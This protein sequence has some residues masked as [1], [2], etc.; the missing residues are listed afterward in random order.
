MITSLEKLRRSQQNFWMR[1]KQDF[2]AAN[3][4][5]EQRH[6][7]AG[8]HG[9]KRRPQR[10]D[11]R[12]A[13]AQRPIFYRSGTTISSSTP[14]PSI[15]SAKMRNLS[16]QSAA[17]GGAALN[18]FNDRSGACGGKMG[19]H[20]RG[21]GRQS[22]VHAHLN[23]FRIGRIFR[24]TPPP[25]PRIKHAQSAKTSQEAD[26][27]KLVERVFSQSRRRRTTPAHLFAHLPISS[28]IRIGALV[29]PSPKTKQV[30][31]LS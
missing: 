16:L 17:H 23:R 14:W 11:R 21:N 19:G 10:S 28:L 26:A 31:V 8:D 4:P 2:K 1:V 27:K 13:C 30:D 18:A 25:S 29:W 15:A 9:L 12:L 7:K 6:F 5:F 22:V 3:I 20:L 24:P